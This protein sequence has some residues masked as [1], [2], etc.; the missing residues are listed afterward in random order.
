MGAFYM[1]TIEVSLDKDGNSGATLKYNPPPSGP[2][3]N[4]FKVGQD[5]EFSVKCGNN[6]AGF[7]FVSAIFI[8]AKES[9]LTERSNPFNDEKTRIVKLVAN[10][11]SVFHLDGD[12]VRDSWN[13]AIV[14]IMKDLQNAERLFTIDPTIT[15]VSRV[16]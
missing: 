10:R 4:H 12:R 13:Y 8:F 9:G 5:V 3:K 11:P 15:I 2:D 16:A 7:T 6:C 14:I 1:G